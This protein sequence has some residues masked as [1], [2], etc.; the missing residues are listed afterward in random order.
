MSAAPP[1]ATAAPPAAAPA[2]RPAGGRL[3][4]WILGVAAVVV[5]G[6]LARIPLVTAGPRDYDEGVYWLSLRRLA[7][8]DALFG[9]VYSSQPPFFLPLLLP[10]YRLLG[11]GLTSVRVGTLVLGAVGVAAG[12]WA[13]GRLGGRAAALLTAVLLSL[14][15]LGLLD[16]T[17]VLAEGPALSVALVSVALAAEVAV[18]AA[19]RRPRTRLWLSGGAGAV[20]AVAA[21]VKLLALPALIPVA[22]L[23]SAPRGGPPPRQRLAAAAAGAAAV[24][25]A[26]VVA[27]HADLRPLME[28]SIGLHLASRSL[29]EGG[30]S[31]DVWLTALRE[32]PLA[33]LAVLGAVRTWRSPRHRR[34]GV[35][36]GLWA[37]TAMAAVAL[38]HPLWPHHVSAVA[39]PLALLAGLAVAPPV[40]RAWGLAAMVAVAGGTLVWV[41]AW[42]YQSLQGAGSPGGDASV[43]AGLRAQLAP[44]SLVV[45]DDQASVAQAGLE[46]PPELVDTSLVRIRST[47]MTSA[48][49]EGVIE[50]EHVRAVLFATGRLDRVP[51]LR[52]WVSAHLPLVVDLGEGR[53]LYLAPAP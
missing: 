29:D 41:S 23:V 6:A 10:F 38:Q 14:D 2:A 25:V 50:R 40:R 21:G 24:A 37:V 44:G 5:V 30:F 19:G 39:P 13:A 52:D 22:I 47:G 9:A 26:T 12:A 32:L 42:S 53:V 27:F 51:G 31:R 20:V 1:L 7:H 17:T 15:P 18:P 34:A 35:A 46:A 36:M 8:G 43:I 33:L 48:D 49:V 3:L 16:S 11:E 28:Q 4:A 45:S